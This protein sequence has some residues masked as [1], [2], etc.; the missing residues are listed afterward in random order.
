MIAI[1]RVMQVDDDIPYPSSRNL[2][3]VI[4]KLEESTKNLFPLV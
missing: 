3:G 2:D 4:N 1:L